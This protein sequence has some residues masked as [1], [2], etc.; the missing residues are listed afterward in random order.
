MRVTSKG[1]VTIPKEI[2]VRL[3]IQPEDEVEFLWADGQVT[4]RKTEASPRRGADLVRRMRGK[5][6]IALSTEEILALTRER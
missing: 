3:D 5:G 6:T 2:R 4:L 1:Q